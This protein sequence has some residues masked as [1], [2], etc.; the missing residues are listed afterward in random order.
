MVVVEG[1]GCWLV[2]SSAPESLSGVF[3]FSLRGG[4]YP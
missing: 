3:H 1:G 2:G 4:A